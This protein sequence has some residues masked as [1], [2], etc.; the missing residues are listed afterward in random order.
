MAGFKDVNE[1]DVE[2][3]DASLSNKD[4]MEMA[5]VKA[6]TKEDEDNSEE[7]NYEA[8]IWKQYVTSSVALNMQ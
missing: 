5:Q 2:S 7:E 3:H 8:L 4:L 1:D 6:F